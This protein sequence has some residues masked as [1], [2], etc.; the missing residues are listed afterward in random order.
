MSKLSRYLNLHLSG[1]VVTETSILKR[2]A[3]DNGPVE[4]L[5]EMV[6]YPRST[7]DIRKLL[8]FV[9]QL[10]EKGHKISVSSRG[11]GKNA[12]G[13][14]VGNGIILAFASHFNKIL[15]YGEKQKLVRVQPGLGMDNL[16]NALSLFG[17]QVRG[18]GEDIEGTVGGWLAHS[19]QTKTVSSVDKLEVVLS[20][21]DIL[22]TERVSKRELGRIK[23]RQGFASDIYRAVET[24]LEENETIVSKLDS[25]DS[26]GYSSLAS[27]RA[28]DG[29]IDLT[30]LFLG[31]DGTLGIIS[32]V[33]LKT[34][35]YNSSTSAVA[36]A[37]KSVGQ[38][39]D[40]LDEIAK[41]QGPEVELYD[42]SLVSSAKLVGKKLEI[43]S[44]GST[45]LVAYVRDMNTRAQA[46]KIKKLLKIMTK[47][48]ASVS[49][50]DD[51]EHSELV[52]VKT[53]NYLAGTSVNGFTALNILDGAFVPLERFDDFSRGITE[54][55]QKLHIDIP[56]AGYPLEN[57]WTIHPRVNLSTVGG[58]QVIFK[59]MDQ[60]ASLVVKCGGHLA[61]ANSEGRI[62]SLITAKHQT[63][64][65]KELYKK[66]KMIFD[67]HGILNTDV[68]QQTDLKA[69]VKQLR[70]NYSAD[71][72]RI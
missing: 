68:K 31:S 30:P 36:G 37:F 42:S 40:A 52:E 65:E 11:Y 24:L 8:K 28:K 35:Y 50:T 59:L 56:L 72:P 26:S 22:Q 64:E 5:P 57:L 63:Q 66:L 9:S 12:V 69:L 3:T 10:A 44:D 54:L 53:I 34:E 43:A 21:G 7:H 29:S 6:V 23:G 61:S 51:F 45:L 47:Y 18:A 71:D 16:S 13:S 39:R 1:E 14:A 38:V 20:N 4:I 41:I 32:E 15:E 25:R 17:T 58:K 62:Q 46:K 70:T 2:Y 60:Y 19:S 33:I 27:I 67:P 49:S 48:K 55:E